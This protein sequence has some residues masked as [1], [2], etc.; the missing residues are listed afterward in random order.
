MDMQAL[1]W[2]QRYTNINGKDTIIWRTN[3]HFKAGSVIRLITAFRHRVRYALHKQQPFP[4][5]ILLL[6]HFDDIQIKK[7]TCNLK[8]TDYRLQMNKENSIY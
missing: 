4:E 2:F 1:H 8:I 7:E 3:V 6:N 5:V